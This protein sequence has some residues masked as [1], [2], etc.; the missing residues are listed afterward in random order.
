MLMDSYGL[1]W[2][3]GCGVDAPEADLLKDMAG[4]SAF[5]RADSP[6]LPR[7]CIPFTSLYMSTQIPSPRAISRGDRAFFFFFTRLWFIQVPCTPLL[8]TLCGGTQ[9][10]LEEHCDDQQPEST[11]PG[12]AQQAAGLLKHIMRCQSLRHTWK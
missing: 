8:S 12:T 9:T 3:M 6:C 1:A 7:E 4:G 11:R 10:L 5:Y 2:R